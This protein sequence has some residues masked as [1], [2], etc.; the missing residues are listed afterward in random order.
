MAAKQ[1]K[2]TEKSADFAKGGNTAMFGKQ[3]VGTQTP[4]GTAHKVSGDEKFASGG[5]G[6]M[7]GFA[8]SQPARAG[9]TSAR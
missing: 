3:H 5:S 7:H 6:K 1:K 2:I 4:G 8:G 9:I